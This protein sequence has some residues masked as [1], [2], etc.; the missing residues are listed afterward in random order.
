[1]SSGSPDVATPEAEPAASTNAAQSEYWN[2]TVGPTWVRFQALLDRQL[3]PL[4]AAAVA[5]LAPASGERVLD[6]G[7]GCGASTLELAEAVG[8]TGRVL[9]VDLSRPML[10]LAESRRSAPTQAAEFCVL[11]AETGD[12][13][14]GEF[15]AVYSRFGMMFFANPVA[16]FANLRRALGAGGRLSFVCWRSLADNDWMRLPLE[17]VRPLLPLLPPS[18]PLAPGPFALADRDRVLHLLA[19]AGFRDA[20]CRPFDAR[21]SAGDVGASVELA[22]HV[23]PV[24]AALRENPDARAGAERV[25]QQFFTEHGGPDGV[26]L[27]S[28]VW[29]VTAL[30]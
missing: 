14:Y 13:G 2:Q 4:G 9:G 15:D 22:L 3:A 12:P 5:A 25:L 28:G 10:A 11:D 18:D 6:V 23:G 16:A 19:A 29:I 8:P 20:E 17:A 24:G 21:L 27:G 1:M 26:R 7:C 30:A